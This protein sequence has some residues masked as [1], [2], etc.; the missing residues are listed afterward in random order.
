MG[1]RGGGEQRGKSANLSSNEYVMTCWIAVKDEMKTVH[2]FV[3]HTRGCLLRERKKSSCCMSAS[4]DYIGYTL[5]FCCCCCCGGCCGCISV[6]A[7]RTFGPQKGQKPSP[8]AAFIIHYFIG[9][10]FSAAHCP[11]VNMKFLDEVSC[12]FGVLFRFILCSAARAR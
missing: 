12:Y 6:C 11:N 10:L 5:C 7:L 8:G 9:S 1:W 4:I 3:S 2:F